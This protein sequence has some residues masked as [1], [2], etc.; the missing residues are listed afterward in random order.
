MTKTTPE[1]RAWLDSL[2]VGDLVCVSCDGHPNGL[3]PIAGRTA[4]A[5]VVERARFSKQTGRMMGPQCRAVNI[6]PVTDEIRAKLRRAEIYRSVM[7]HM[8][9]GVSTNVL[10]LIE[11]VLIWQN[12]PDVI[13]HAY[14]AILGL[15]KE[16]MEAQR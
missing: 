14:D 10:E 13:V 15:T 3:A 8:D 5:I 7:D 16:R 1:R 6:E 4:M 11:L 12:S 9:W 2:K